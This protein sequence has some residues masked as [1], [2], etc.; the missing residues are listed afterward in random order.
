VG[1]DAEV[2]RPRSRCRGEGALVE[3]LALGHHLLVL[4]DGEGAASGEEGGELERA[5]ALLGSR[6]DSAGEELG[7][8][9]AAVAEEPDARA[10]E[11]GG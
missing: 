3:G 9:A 4:G 1:V 6:G 2:A 11:R 10:I 5:D 7:A 8:G